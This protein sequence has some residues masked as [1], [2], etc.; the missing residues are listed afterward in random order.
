MGEP[1]AFQL[2]GMIVLLVPLV[3][4]PC[5]VI[6]LFCIRGYTSK[7][8]RFLVG[9][10]LGPIGVLYADHSQLRWRDFVI[11]AAS[12]LVYLWLC[13]SVAQSMV[14]MWLVNQ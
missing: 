10:L 13:A 2:L 1:S 7:L 11:L 6:G 3:A 8:R 4:A 14:L 12:A 9:W 5:G